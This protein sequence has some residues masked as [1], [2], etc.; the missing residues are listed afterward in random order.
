MFVADSM[1]FLRAPT[2]SIDS[3]NSAQMINKIE[4]LIRVR[5]LMMV[6]MQ[7]AFCPVVIFGDISLDIIGVLMM[8]SMTTLIL[9]VITTIPTMGTIWMMVLT[10]PVQRCGWNSFVRLSSGQR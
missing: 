8:T 5:N 2:T 7:S 9:M 3:V 10:I 1:R 4:V 6:L